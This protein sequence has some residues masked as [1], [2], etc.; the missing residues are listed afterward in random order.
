MGLYEAFIKCDCSIAEINPLVV[1]KEGD[2]LCLDAKMNFDS[3]A[4]YRQPQILELRD[5][6][7]EEPTEIEAS[8]FDLPLLSLTE[9]L[10]A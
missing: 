9:T 1:T 6:N 7:E 10:A 4:L 2:V 5:L 3:N 8:K